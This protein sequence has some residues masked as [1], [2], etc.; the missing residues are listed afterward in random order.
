MY[1]DEQLVVK[2]FTQK[3][4]VNIFFGKLK[5]TEWV[6]CIKLMPEREAEIELNPVFSVKLNFITHKTKMNLLI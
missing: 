5:K 2:H 6:S 4:A 1:L 3:L